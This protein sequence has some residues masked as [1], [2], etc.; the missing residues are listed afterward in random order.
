MVTSGTESRNNKTE[1][2][3][4]NILLGVVCALGAFTALVLAEKFFKKEGVMAWMV[5]A[6]VLANIFLQK[7]IMIGPIA[8]TLGNILFASNYLATDILSEKYGVKESKKAIKLSF[9]ALI[10]FIASTQLALL[11]V[12]SAED[13]AQTAMQTLF[14]TGA[15]I[16]AA[17]LIC[18]YASNMLD[19]WL[20]AK[21]K[22]KTGEKKLWLRNNVATIISNC[23]ENFALYFLAFGG[24]M[25]AGL[26]LQMGL[27]ASI[28]EIALA[29]CDTPFV[30]WSKK[31]GTKRVKATN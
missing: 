25:D 30:Y 2:K 28:I 10:F 22:S 18:Y 24:I 19:V 21:I 1:E 6:T 8:A 26:L 13:F 5:L 17:S 14:T 15:R 11:F 29:L 12:P 27:S 16:A 7:S 9:F 31:W 3:K 23:V 20:F 4:M